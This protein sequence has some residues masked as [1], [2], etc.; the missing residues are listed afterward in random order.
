[1]SISF[2]GKARQFTGEIYDGIQVRQEFEA[3]H[4]SLLS[5]D[6]Y[7]ATYMRT[8][9]GFCHVGI[10]DSF[11]K[12]ICSETFSLQ[13]L[14]DNSYRTVVF[15]AKLIA[16]KKYQ[17]KIWT[18]NCRC[19]RAPTLAYGKSNGSNH[20][21]FGSSLMTGYE[22]TCIFNYDMPK[23]EYAMPDMKTE[24]DSIMGLV[25]IVIPHYNCSNLLK[26][27][28]ASIT[29]QTYK[30]LEVII[31]D[32]G[33][34]EEERKVVEN[35]IVSYKPLL[36]IKYKAN[37]KN[38]GAPFSRNEGFSLSKGSLI[39][40]C[41]ADVVL[42]PDTIE[43]LVTCL[44]DESKG[45]AYGGFIWGGQRIPPVKFD[46]EKLKKGNYITTMSMVRRSVFPGWDVSLKRHQDWDLWLTISLKGIEGICSDR[47][48]FET[49]K[50]NGISTEQN[51]PRVVSEEIIKRKH[52]L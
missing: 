1:M 9:N 24:S 17:L 26:H 41:D 36:D 5:V 31:V 13:R 44:M 30:C 37:E 42:Y 33:S 4:E 11:N 35:I 49:P 46:L 21:Y 2:G 40:F 6:I 15:N 32:D 8:N 20:F 14:E 3:E 28:L 48:L 19:G 47:Y 7:F 16:G 27:T 23:K 12:Q 25:S 50:R 52:G 10:Y 34:T 45:F 51:I 22:L 18:E 29:H 38:M 39:Y 43:V